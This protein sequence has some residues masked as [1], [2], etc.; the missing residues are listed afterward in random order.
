MNTTRQY[1]N[2]KATNHTV[3]TR[4]MRPPSHKAGRTTNVK[5]D[6]GGVTVS[7]PPP[8][9]SSYKQLT[10]FLLP[11]PLQIRRCPGLQ[12]AVGNHV[13][14][15]IDS[16]SFPLSSGFM[17]FCHDSG[18]CIKVKSSYDPYYWSDHDK[19]EFN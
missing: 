13:A 11:I 17:C 16:C 12:A 3:L 2:F 9:P 4:C 5:G 7:T 1:L 8:S 15:D 14:A 19:H 6:R 10:T 18:R